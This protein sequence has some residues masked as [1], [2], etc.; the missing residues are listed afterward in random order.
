MQVA[1]QS[2]IEAEIVANRSHNLEDTHV[3]YLLPTKNS[4]S[5]ESPLVADCDRICDIQGVLLQRGKRTRRESSEY[6]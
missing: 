3:L 5:M 2:Q 6:E 4:L 1:A